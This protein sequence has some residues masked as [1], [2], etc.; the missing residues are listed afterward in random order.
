MLPWGAAR[1]PGRLLDLA[2]SGAVTRLAGDDLLAFLQD[3]LIP[4]AEALQVDLTPLRAAFPIHDGAR[5]PITWQINHT[6]RHGIGEYWAVPY[7][8]AGASA[9]ALASV[10]Q[11]GNAGGRF[12]RMGEAWLE[13]TPAFKTR[14][15]QWQQQNAGPLQLVPQEVLG[16]Y[17]KRLTQLHLTPPSITIPEAATETEQV[18]QQIATLQ[19]HGLPVGMTGLAQE[20][21]TLLA[22][23]CAQL[24]QAYSQAHILWVV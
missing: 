8:G 2:R 21:P 6:I 19:Q 10:M 15:T 17:R 24:L 3:D 4:N 11:H 7:L 13:Y 5:L 12:L 20:V 9:V 14:C 18:R 23:T 22:Q 1:L 16:S